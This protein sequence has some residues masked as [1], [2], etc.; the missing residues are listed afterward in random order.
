MH[1]AN[2]ALYSFVSEQMEIVK[3]TLMLN[4]IE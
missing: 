4:G 2:V 1:V 3:G